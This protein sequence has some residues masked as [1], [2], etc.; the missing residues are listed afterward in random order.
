MS[1]LE[2]FEPRVDPRRLEVLR[3]R[4]GD[5]G[6]SGGASA[7]SELLRDVCRRWAGGDGFRAESFT[8]RLRFGESYLFEGCHLIASHP[9]TEVHELPVLAIHGWPS[10]PMEFRELAPLLA[11]AGHALLAP[12]LPGYGFSRPLAGPGA[13]VACA[14]LFADAMRAAGYQRYAVVAGDWGSVIACCLAQRHP[15]SVAGIYVTTPGA[16]PVPGSIEGALSEEE[17]RYLGAAQ[18]WRTRDG[19][20]LALHGRSAAALAPGLDE[21]PVAC[22]AYLLSRLDAWSGRGALEVFGLD[23]L[24][25]LLS[26]YWLTATAG[27]AVELYALEASA[28]WRLAAGETIRA[29]AACISPTADILVPPEAWVRRVLGELG[30]WTELTNVGHFAAAEAPERVAVDLLAFLDQL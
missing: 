21:S 16:L 24:S 6:E 23:G 26:F 11:E 3:R 8:E 2:P 12:S 30:G 17:S 28:R 19:W 7:G 9:V 29:P 5:F 1:E 15:E 22:A 18:A 10:S 14:D 27:S 13:V 25:D 20:H 4:L